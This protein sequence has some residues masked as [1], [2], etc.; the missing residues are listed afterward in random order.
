MPNRQKRHDMRLSPNAQQARPSYA[1]PTAASAE[2]LD[3]GNAALNRNLRSRE[4]ISGLRAALELLTLLDRLGREIAQL[5]RQKDAAWH[6]LAASQT[7]RWNYLGQIDRLTAK[8]AQLQME[9]DGAWRF[10]IIAS[11]TD[12]EAHEALSLL[13]AQAATDYPRSV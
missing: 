1:P 11:A 5:Q 8:I 4:R 12:S 13:Q 6:R 10:L 7:R 3:R 9:R 2:D